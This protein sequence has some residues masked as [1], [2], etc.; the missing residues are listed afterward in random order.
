MGV[1]LGLLDSIP[2]DQ[3]L[4]ALL[5]RLHAV[6]GEPVRGQGD[7][8]RQGHAGAVG[9]GAHGQ[10]D[11]H[12]RVADATDLWG[13]GIGDSHGIRGRCARCGRSM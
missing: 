7:D 13:L 5:K 3:H 11:A 2:P 10:A 9:P 6:V 1:G 12:V 4:L 8:Q